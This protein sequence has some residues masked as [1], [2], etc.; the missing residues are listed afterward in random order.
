[1]SHVMQRMTDADPKRGHK[2]G[3]AGTAEAFYRVFRALPRK[4]RMAVAHYILA[5]TEVQKTL[6]LPEMPN[7]ITVRAFTE[8]KHSM[9]IFDTVDELRKD[10][11]S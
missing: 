10:L 3:A 7:E 1:M 4:E 6:A 8:D 2:A 5:D 9:P 11:V